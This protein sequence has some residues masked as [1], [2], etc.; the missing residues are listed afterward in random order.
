M[1]LAIRLLMKIVNGKTVSVYTEVSIW[2]KI[3]FLFNARSK[4][5]SR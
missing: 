1:I 2:S 5:A 3:E 4:K